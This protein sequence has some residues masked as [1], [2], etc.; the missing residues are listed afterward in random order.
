MRAII[1]AA[2]LAAPLTCAAQTLLDDY[3]RVSQLVQ[4]M[5]TYV[6]ETLLACAQ[7]STLTE[8]Q[9]E[10]RFTAYRDRNAALLGRIEAWSR[11]ADRRLAASGEAH[12]GRRQ[13]EDAGITG[14]AAASQQVEGEFRKVRDVAAFCAARIG[15]IENGRLDISGNAELQ[16]LLAK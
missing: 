16:Q 13:S 11:E 10:A 15:A 9:A 12:E 14:M 1:A 2:A 6:G 7:A 5:T 3:A 8:Q 4:Y